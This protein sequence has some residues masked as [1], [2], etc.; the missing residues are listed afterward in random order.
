MRELDERL[1]EI[2]GETSRR[3]KLV[4]KP[5]R[6]SDWPALIHKHRQM[7]AILETALKQKGELTPPADRAEHYWSYLAAVD[8]QL[9]LE[10]AVLQAAQTRDSRAYSQEC[11]LLAASVDEAL[12]TGRRAGLRSTQPTWTQPQRIRM[13]L[14]IYVVRAL[15]HARGEKRAGHRWQSS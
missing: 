5:T 13:T 2:N 4:A 10:R 7:L 11:R 9:R 8:R 15:W 3:L 1:A 12:L 6:A 14:P